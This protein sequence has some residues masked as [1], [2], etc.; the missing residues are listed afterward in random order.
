[1]SFVTYLESI[2]KGIALVVVLSELHGC[3]VS[4]GLMLSAESKYTADAIDAIQV[5]V[6][7]SSKDMRNR[8]KQIANNSEIRSRK[9][10][11]SAPVMAYRIAFA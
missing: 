7:I 5:K 4:F 6:T 3:C 2:Y 10:L 8:E 1:M 9:V 11:V